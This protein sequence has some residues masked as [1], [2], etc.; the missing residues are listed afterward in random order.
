[1]VFYHFSLEKNLTGLYL[2]GG[3]AEA[4]IFWSSGNHSLLPFAGSR[5][6]FLLFTLPAPTSKGTSLIS[7]AVTKNATASIQAAIHLIGVQFVS[8]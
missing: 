2:A 4:S 1:M 3:F 7:L 8:I 6:I 5:M